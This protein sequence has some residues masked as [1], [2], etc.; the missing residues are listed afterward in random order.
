MKSD[1]ELVMLFYVLYIRTEK[2]NSIT[3]YISVIELRLVNISCLLI[4][5]LRT[6]AW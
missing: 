5:E 4:E 2:I 3:E 6:K 1:L